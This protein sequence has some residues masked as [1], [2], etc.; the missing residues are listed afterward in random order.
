MWQNRIQNQCVVLHCTFSKVFVSAVIPEMLC[1][2]VPLSIFFWFYTFEIY[3]QR[4]R[5]A[6]K[7]GFSQEQGTSWVQEMKNPG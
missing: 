6:G 7:Q 1:T 4:K 3:C 2:A 5:P